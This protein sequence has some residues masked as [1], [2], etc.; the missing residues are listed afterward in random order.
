MVKL[1]LVYHGMQYHV[2][3][4]TMHLNHGTPGIILPNHTVTLKVYYGT[5]VHGILVWFYYSKPCYIVVLPCIQTMEN[6]NSLLWKKL[7]WYINYIGISLHQ[8]VVSL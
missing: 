6:V 3:G 5:M 4:I 7:P 1:Y 8:T 2:S